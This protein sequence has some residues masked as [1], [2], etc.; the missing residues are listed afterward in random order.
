MEYLTRAG[1]QA[2]NRSAYA[3]AQTQLQQGLE[4]IKKVPEAPERDARELE[5]TS[6]L[7]Q[8]L[9]VTRGQTAPETLAAAGRAR[10]LAEKSG[11]LAQLVAQ[12]LGIWRTLSVSG[13]YATAALLADRLLDLAQREGSPASFGFACFAQVDVRFY[14]GDLV[15]AEAHFARWGGFLDADGFRQV[16]GAAVT[17][18]GGASLCA[19]ALGRA[20]IARERLA[21]A[22]AFARDSSN[23]YDLGGARTFESWLSCW[24]REP[25]RAEVAATQ[26]VAIGEEH[27]FQLGLNFDRLLLGWARAQLG[28]AGEGVALIRR[29]L[30]GLAETGARLGI[31]HFLSCLAEAQAL[32]GKLDDALVTIEQALSANPE[33]LVFQPNALTCRGA[34]LIKLG[35]PELAE[36][37]FR[38]AIALAQKMQAKSWELRAAMSLARLLVSQGNRGEARAMLAEIYNWFTEG[39][40]TADLKDAKVLLDEFS[41]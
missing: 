5:L 10:D 18:I 35:Q 31:T 19:W 9:L 24:L 6:T 29:G 15:Q 30:A 3:E 39:F 16:S 17:A 27:G 21:R 32:D 34:V 20:D 33:E 22:L 25:Q 7:A 38:E 26:A 36:T 40:D 12:E 2:L 28:H 37:D 11:N 13:D 8:V 23:L 14:R 1:Q 41:T 4:W